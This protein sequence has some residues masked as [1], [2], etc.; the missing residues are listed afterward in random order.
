MGN[1]ARSGDPNH[2]VYAEF[3]LGAAATLYGLHPHMHGRGKDFL[4][5]IKFPSGVS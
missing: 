3:E 2:R 1:N 4:Y 5:Q